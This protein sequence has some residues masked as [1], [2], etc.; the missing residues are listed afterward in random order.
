M[1]HGNALILKDRISYHR[2][3]ALKKEKI[4]N[5]QR[6]KNVIT[7]KFLFIAS[8]LSLFLLAVYIYAKDIKVTLKPRKNAYCSPE[9]QCGGG[10]YVP[11]VS[12][13]GCSRTFLRSCSG[14]CF[15]CAPST[16]VGRY[17][18]EEEGRQCGIPWP[19]DLRISCG[20]KG[21]YQCKNNG[22]HGPS[23]CCPEYEQN[24]QVGEKCTG[25][26]QC[27]G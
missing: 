10:V 5:K 8:L 6:N 2:D 14:E 16:D 17:C 21:K 26:S 23:L 1:V 27:D 9:Q 15:W 4:M 12:N 11:D 25:I 3:K 22:G 18:I 24:Q 19:S 13:D 7:K 20:P